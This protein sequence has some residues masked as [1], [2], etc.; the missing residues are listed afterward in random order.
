MKNKNKSGALGRVLRRAANARPWVL[1]LTGIRSVQ[2]LAAIAYA[3][4]LRSL[5]DAA[6]A[7][8]ESVF[9]HR[10]F[11]FILLAVFSLAL[12]ALGRYVREKGLCRTEASLRLYVFSN[13]LQGSFPKVTGTH[14]GEWMT[15]ITSDASVVSA[16]VMSI[17]PECAGSLFRLAGAMAALI[18]LAPRVAYILVP[19]GVILAIVSFFLR[20]KLKQ[21]HRASQAADGASR[22]HMQEHLSSLLVLRTFSQEGSSV[23]KAG[24]H[25]AV[26]V[27]ARMHRAV[28]SN[29][30]ST[31]ITGIMTAAQIIGI[32]LCGWGIVHGSVTFG[33]LSATIYL[34]G[35]L[36]AP[37]A[38]ISGYFSQYYAML[39]SAE[40][41]AETEDLIEQ[42]DTL[43][44]G[45]AVQTYYQDRFSAIVFENVDFSYE[46][47]GYRVLDRKSFRIEKGSITAFTGGSGSGKS[48]VLKMMLCLYSPD[49]GQIS[50]TNT[51][52]SKMP[53]S[54]A[55]R[56]L[57]AY[58]PQGNFLFSGT[59]R[60]SLTFADPIS[61]AQEDR[62]WEAL[63]LACASDFVR[64]LP[65]GLDT[66]LGERGI[67]LSEG[68][69]Q[70]LAIA[71]ALIANRPILLLDEATSA[72][73][74]ETE[75][76]LLDNLRSMTDKTVV[77]VTHRETVAEFC[78]RQ[79]C[80]QNHVHP[81]FHEATQ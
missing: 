46:D 68:Q 39:A 24:E 48:T 71:R 49:S 30:A 63:Q 42:D 61:M 60:E 19:C 38:K 9:G 12:S 58:V 70:R 31:S 26:L 66:I 8:A 51:D 7:G 59:I 47:G 56:S 77:I 50:L 37:F 29:L 80:F 40:R 78:D 2:G 23:R 3:Y 55:M 54:K 25:L 35:M 36:E 17:V 10:L 34:V 41:L 67:G 43:M 14:T 1:L 11:L 62:I 4:M 79:I 57:F 16:A 74:P 13:L 45:K 28:Y 27:K 6:V 33:T 22:A 5:V 65:E 32:T 15:C 53:V 52:D 20:K 44:D 81:T 21:L 76:K 69:I 75:K 18:L 72:L 73:D 64:S